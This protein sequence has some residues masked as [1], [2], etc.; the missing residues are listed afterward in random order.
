MEGFVNTGRTSPFDNGFRHSGRYANYGV[1]TYIKKESR[2]TQ[3]Q[4]ERQNTSIPKPRQSDVLMQFKD[5]NSFV[6]S[7]FTDLTELDKTVVDT[8]TAPNQN[9][10][11]RILTAVIVGGSAVVLSGLSLVLTKGKIPKFITNK[12]GDFAKTID[13]K[14]KTK[15]SKPT[16]SNIE[17]K[18][19]SLLQK[20]NN[21]IKRARGTFFNITPLK[22][23]LFKKLTYEKLGLKKPCDAITESFRK[24]SFS[25]VKTAY[26]NAS[27]DIDEMSKVF[28]DT[29]QKISNGNYG[30]KGEEAKKIA[31]R[32]N[33]R[34]SNI[35]KTF[36]TSFGEPEIENRSKEL[37]DGFK[38]LSD[39]IYDRAYGHMKDFV[40][41]VDMWTSFIPERLVKSKKLK[42]M[43]TLE[44]KKR[45][46]T[47]SPKDNYRHIS[48]SIDQLEEV[49]NPEHNDSLNLV[50]RLR[51]LS[52]NYINP[53]GENKTIRRQEV[54]KTINEQGEEL[55]RILAS[56]IYTPTQ[57]KTA[58]EIFQTI[59]DNLNN[60]KKGE[61]E[62]IL[63]VYRELLPREEYEKI[64]KVVQKSNKSLN[65]AVRREGFEYVDKVRDLSIG[66]ALTDVAI[67]MALPIFSTGIAVSAADTKEKKRSVILKYGIPLLTGMATATTCTIRLISGG[68]AL[69]LGGLVSILS[70]EICE[71]IDNHLLSKSSK[72]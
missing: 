69:I 25:T 47:N 29:N 13:E 33:Q 17:G 8:V 38:N 23:S 32:L 2:E 4:Q 61:V 15:K 10:E 6:G 45:I 36:H 40:Y 16:L 65:K 42:F 39:E 14:I 26:K 54:V 22:D 64:K 43:N 57:R 50:K 51:E 53:V 67:G 20:T 58:K 70:N 41:D 71:R 18:Y 68:N 63:T 60:D 12:L 52:K 28:F 3:N 27:K 66:S 19:L 1:E 62:E 7:T 46:I 49:I 24:I 48:D 21:V 72:K 55:E 11:Q 30:I 56:D 9:K 5:M 59:T 44:N 34:T 31:N 37:V 35:Q